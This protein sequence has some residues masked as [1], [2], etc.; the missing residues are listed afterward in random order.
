MTDDAQETGLAWPDP[1]RGPT[2]PEYQGRPRDDELPT[3]RP[4]GWWDRTK[5]LVFVIALWGVLVWTAIAQDPIVSLH[6]AVALVAVLHPELFHTEELAGD[7]EVSGEIAMGATIFD[8]RP[9]APHRADLE[10]AL[11]IDTSARTVRRARNTPCSSGSNFLAWS[12]LG[13]L[14]GVP[15]RSGCILRLLVTPSLGTS[16]MACKMNRLA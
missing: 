10:I 12:K 14:L 13:L 8:R 6:D 1:D 7:V 11:E 16:R 9:T 2:P 15:I 5:F 4:L 3:R